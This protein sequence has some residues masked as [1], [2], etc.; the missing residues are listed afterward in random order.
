V[1]AHG[2]DASGHGRTLATRGAGCYT[3]V[4]SL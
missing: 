2:E 3:M 4:S 1:V